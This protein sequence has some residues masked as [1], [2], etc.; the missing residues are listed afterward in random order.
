MAK[1]K[2][3]DCC[4]SVIDNAKRSCPSRV[5]KKKQKV[6]PAYIGDDEIRNLCKEIVDFYEEAMDSLL[7]S[8]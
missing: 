7:E 3:N 5:K 6:K 8:K 4:E 1:K 2:A